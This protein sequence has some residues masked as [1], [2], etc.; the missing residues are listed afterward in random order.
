MFQSATHITT[1]T[2]VMYLSIYNLSFFFLSFS[3]FRKKKYI[4]I[5]FS[6][7]ASKIRCFSFLRHCYIHGLLLHFRSICLLNIQLSFSRKIEENAECRFELSPKFFHGTF[8][9]S[10][11]WF[12]CYSCCCDFRFGILR[13]FFTRMHTL[14]V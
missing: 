14:E 10:L 1:V 2:K 8:C 9:D 3:S 5:M 13:V 6:N 11:L 12:F 4:I 7:Y